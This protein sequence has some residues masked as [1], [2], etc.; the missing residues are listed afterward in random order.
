[1]EVPPLDQYSI[2]FNKILIDEKC[3]SYSDGFY[4]F[5]LSSEFWFTRLWRGQGQFSG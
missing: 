3:I 2:R 5:A 4:V 1:M